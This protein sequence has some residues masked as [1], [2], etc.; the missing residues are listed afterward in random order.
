MVG[1]MMRK[2]VMMIKELRDL[3]PHAS[4]VT[5]AVGYVL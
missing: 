2:M 5:N 4:V 1:V 3:T